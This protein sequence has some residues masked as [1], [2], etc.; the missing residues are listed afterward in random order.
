MLQV[1]G[2]HL[3]DVE[4]RNG[5]KIQVFE[6]QVG[7]ETGV[8]NVR[9]AGEYASKLKPSHVVCIRN[10]KSSVYKEHHR[11]ELDQ[12]GVVTDNKDE[13]KEVP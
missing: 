5:E 12:W 6:G 10:L 4:R 8:I 3:T 2:G 1:L 11:I 13:A 9:I 7:D